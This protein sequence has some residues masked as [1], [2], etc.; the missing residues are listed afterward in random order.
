M[1]RRFAVVLASVAVTAA[2]VLLAAPAGAAADFTVNVDAR[3]TARGI[4]HVKQSFPAH[5]GPMALSYPRWI[6]G[7]H[8]PTGPN[9]DVAGLVIKANGQTLPWTR[10]GVDMNTV[11]VNVPTGAKDVSVA[12]DFLLDNGTDG[13]TSA[14]CSTPNLLLLSWNEVTFY[15][16]GG[17]S[18]ALTCNATL[19]LP[20]RWQ[21]ASAL[22]EESAAGAAIHFR[23]CSFT[24][25]LDS[26]LLSVTHFRTLELTPG[27]RLPIPVRI[28]C[29]SEKGLNI[30]ATKIQTLKILS[31]ERKPL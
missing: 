28:A 14:A 2:G 8:G 24:T 1:P 19:T 15:P 13:F 9:V 26:P 5:A 30:P 18:D 20:D 25:L 21:H 4:L 12:F 23:P 22:D 27:D 7:E 16:A 31:H 6:P 11:R 10:D 3:E 29:H 17:K